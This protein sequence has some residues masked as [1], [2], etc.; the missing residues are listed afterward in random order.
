MRG[1][2]EFQID[3]ERIAVDTGQLV[4]IA[5]TATRKLMPGPDGVRVLAIGC[6]GERPYER[7]EDFRLA[8]RA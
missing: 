2:A 8:V 5:P 4:R 1:S 6:A 3:G 7:P